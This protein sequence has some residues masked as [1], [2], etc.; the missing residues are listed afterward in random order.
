MSQHREG[1]YLFMSASRCLLSD[2]RRDSGHK[3][4]H[5]MA[6]SKFL[7]TLHE[8]YLSGLRTKQTIGRVYVEIGR[9][10]VL[11]VNSFLVRRCFGWHFCK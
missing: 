2:R 3:T 11:R 6:F 9:K 8:K 10:C 5:L 4:T 1:I 7:D